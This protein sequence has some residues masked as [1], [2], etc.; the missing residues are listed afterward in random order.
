VKQVAITVT[1][2]GGGNIYRSTGG[3]GSN[4]T[5]SVSVSNGKVSVSGSGIELDN[6]S[7]AA[8]SSA[9]NFNITQLQ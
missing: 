3:N 8:D 2:G 5:V 9:L 7:N 4:Q 6:I 1:T